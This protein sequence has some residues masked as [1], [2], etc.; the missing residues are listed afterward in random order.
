MKQ[1]IFT[2][3]ENTALNARYSRLVLVGDTSAI[4]RPGQFADVSI[5][6][7]FLRRP[8]SVCD[9]TEETLT[10]IYETVGRGTEALKELPSGTAL[11]VLEETT[12]TVS[13]IDA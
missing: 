9:W 6:G 7:F 13:T 11:D 5:P 4:V 1:S 10:L 8:F 12:I 2:V 3:R